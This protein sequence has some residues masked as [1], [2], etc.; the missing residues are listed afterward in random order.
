MPAPDDPA[1]AVAARGNNLVFAAPPAPAF[2]RPLLEALIGSPR[3]SSAGP[4]LAVSPEAALFAWGEAAATAARAVGKRSAIGPNPNRAGHHLAANR[5]DLLTTTLP[6]ATELLR[7]SAL[8]PDELPAVLLI[9]P[10]L[11]LSDEAFVPLFADLP[12]TTQRLLIT[13]DPPAVA[14]VAERYAWRAPVLGPLASPGPLPAV[15]RMRTVSVS[16]AGR[17]AALGALADL[18][19]LDEVV[20]WTADPREATSLGDRLAVHGAAARVVTGTAIG[21]EPVVFYDLP[22]PALLTQAHP[23]STVLVPPGTEGY[24]ARLIGQRVPLKLP[25]ASDQLVREIAADRETIRSRIEAGPDRGAYATL[26]PLLE[27]WSATDVALALQSLWLEARRR[28][29]APAA[30]PRSREPDRG[31]RP[32][33]R[34]WVGIGKKD[35]VTLGEWLALLTLDLGLG[36]ESLGKIELRDTFTLIELPGEALAGEVAEKL[37]GRT[38]KNRR[39]TARIDRGP[40]RRGPKRP[41]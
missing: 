23:R 24:A 25:N 20:V 32:G 22:I 37:A 10:E 13:A 11:E 9:W 5:V 36:R 17:S 34:V 31:S 18:D 41:A 15:P 21:T 14:A 38:F 26:A 1:V 33:A 27:R 2:A 4:V 3:D 12:K 8:R 6:V 19:D 16:W 40:S 29:S 28:E 39:L 7:R 35:G 30:Q